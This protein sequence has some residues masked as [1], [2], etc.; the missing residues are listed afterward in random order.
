MGL[1]LAQRLI[2]KGI[3]NYANNVLLLL[4]LHV[5]RGRAE[6][7]LNYGRDSRGTIVGVSVTQ[8]IFI[9]INTKSQNRQWASINCT[10]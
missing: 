1:I 6:L 9:I 7:L 5:Y 4:L 2:I 3:C 10:K 8:V